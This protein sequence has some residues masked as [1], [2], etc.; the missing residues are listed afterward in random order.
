MSSQSAPAARLQFSIA[1]LLSYFIGMAVYFAMWST[2][3]SW[4]Q[5]PYRENRSLAMLL[6][7]VLTAWAVLQWLYRTWR[8]PQAETV[9]FAGP[10]IVLAACGIIGA[11]GLIVLPF[12][13]HTSEPVAGFLAGA[14]I[15]LVASCGVSAAV[16]FP[17]A[18]AMLLYLCMRPVGSE[19]T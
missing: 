5:P 4:M 15:A 6:I 13:H 12:Q 19:T 10:Y 18:T 8:L 14:L 11:I 17:A 3:W 2:W 1:G 9:H 16:S 7:T